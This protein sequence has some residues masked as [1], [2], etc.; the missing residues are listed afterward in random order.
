[1]LCE[2]VINK[3][4]VVLKALSELK[5]SYANLILEL[6]KEGQAKKVFKKNIDVMLMLNTMTG[7]TTQAILNKDY[8]KAF[9]NLKMK[10][11][12]FDALLVDRLRIH[13]KEL[14][15]AILGYEG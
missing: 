4:S 8:Y 5:L 14:F 15:K 11:S 1:M 6:I 10:T 2:Q 9:N 7:T 13:L 12:E 3:N